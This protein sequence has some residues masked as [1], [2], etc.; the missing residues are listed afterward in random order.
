MEPIAEIERDLDQI[1]AD[2]SRFARLETRKE[3]REE[4]Q[5]LDALVV[6]LNR[7]DREMHL[8]R[9]ARK[10]DEALIAGEQDYADRLR[11]RVLHRRARL[12]AAAVR[13]IETLAGVVTLAFLLPTLVAAVYGAEAAIPGRGPTES[14]AA[15]IVLSSV[16]VGF[17]LAVAM[18]LW[19]RGPA[20]DLADTGDD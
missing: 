13:R 4:V 14:A 1:E 2:L 6:E 5:L 7:I 3:H 15:W 16:F 9:R 12:Q 17:V 8:L 10:P 18:W 19:S 11:T 20:R